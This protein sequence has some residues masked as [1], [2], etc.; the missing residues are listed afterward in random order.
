M[1]P[2]EPASHTVYRPTVVVVGA[3]S[4]DLAPD[5]PRGWR[6]GGGVTYGALTL[7]R[8]GV[9]TAC[10]MGVDEAAAGA[11]EL[12]LLHGAGVALLPT[13]LDHGPVFDNVET[14]TG[15]QQDCRSVCDPIP[16]AALP[17]EWMEAPAFLLAPVADE[18]KAEWAD[19]LPVDATV[20]LGWQGLL[21]ELTV[22]RAVQRRPPAENALVRRADLVGLSTDDLESES[23]LGDL[24]ALL[25]QD[26][27]LILTHGAGGGLAVLVGPGGAAAGVV[28]YPAV[29]ARQVDPTGAGDVF[30]ASLLAA[31]LRPRLA[32]GLG[33]RG[34][35]RLAAAVSALVVEA[36]GVT[37]V[38]GAAA[39][40]QRIAAS[41]TAGR[42]RDSGPGR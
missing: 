37:G 10:L 30:L 15:R 21:R 6:L 19:V 14:P 8:L 42:G 31:R 29:A 34:D 12:D 18:L 28:R 4:R 38:P 3:A 1:R 17:R 5:D 7:A 27:T 35:L 20:A 41:R 26:A 11:E 24:L 36:A 16:T 39:I 22:G 33:P 9:R 25:R 13:L 40:A 2:G 23:P 32:A